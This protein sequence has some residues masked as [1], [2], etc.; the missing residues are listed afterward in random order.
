MRK[1]GREVK[2]NWEETGGKHPLEYIAYKKIF[3]TKK[4][5]REKENIA[6]SSVLK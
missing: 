3:S 5:F 2:R 6:T 1:M 4:D